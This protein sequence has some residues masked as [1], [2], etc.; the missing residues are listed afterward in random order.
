MPEK[1]ALT[2]PEVPPTIVDWQVQRLDLD[3]AASRIEIALLGTNGE[4]RAFAYTGTPARTLMVVLNKANLTTNSLHRRILT[5]LVT[6]G[7]LAGI[8]TGLPD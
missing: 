8:V 6:D 7:L 2:M 1:L 5:Q 4:S 3:W